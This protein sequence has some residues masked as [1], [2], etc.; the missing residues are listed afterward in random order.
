MHVDSKLSIGNIITIGV[1]FIS[2]AVS[3]GMV[4]SSI[5]SLKVA[6]ESKADKSVV[7]VKLDYM[8]EDITEIKQM[9][10]EMK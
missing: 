7:N 9:L 6:I 5:N 8:Q 4:K 10:K 3:W 1:L 2:V